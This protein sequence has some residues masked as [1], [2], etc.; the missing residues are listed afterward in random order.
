[1]RLIR[2][3]VAKVAV[4]AIFVHAFAFPGFVGL[5]F[6][7]LAVL[8]A[9]IMPRLSHSNVSLYIATISYLCEGQRLSASFLKTRM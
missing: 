6:V 3:N 8:G 1:M 9:I 4:I 7:W 5:S 2:K